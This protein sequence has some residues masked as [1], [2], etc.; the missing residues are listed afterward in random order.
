MV[1]LGRTYKDMITGFSGIATG[2]ASYISGCNQALLAPPV[3]PSGA[4]QDAQWI[5][6]QRLI[7]TEAPLISLKN[8]DTLGFDREA[9]KR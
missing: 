8:Q 4:L 6:E 9:P 1:T 7:E 5:D 3:S 2:C